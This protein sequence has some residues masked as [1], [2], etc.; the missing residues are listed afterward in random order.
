MVWREP[1]ERREQHL[2]AI[3]L[4][5]QTVGT[6]AS[7]GPAGHV[8][9]HHQPRWSRSPS[10]TGQVVCYLQEIRGKRQPAVLKPGQRARRNTSWVRSSASAGSRVNLAK[11]R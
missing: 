7:H 10:I 3:A 6:W 1:V 4:D 8:R 2:Q 5:G 9:A 11:E